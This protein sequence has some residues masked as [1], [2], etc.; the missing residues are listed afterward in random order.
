MYKQAYQG[1]THIVLL[2]A[3]G[4]D[5]MK[6]WSARRGVAARAYNKDVKTYVIDIVGPAGSKVSCPGDAGS[7]G[8]TGGRVLGLTQPYFALQVYILKD[9]PFSLDLAVTDHLRNRIRLLFSTSYKAVKVTPLHARIPL[10]AVAGSWSC[11]VFDLHE[12]V[13]A[14]F[15]KSE[16]ASV[17]TIDLMPV[18]T[19]LRAL[20]CRACPLPTLELFCQ[21]DEDDARRNPHMPRPRFSSRQHAPLPRAV[22]AGTDVH[23]Q[24][25]D[26]FY[27]GL[28]AE[29]R[30]HADIAVRDQDALVQARTEFVP[31]YANTGLAVDARPRITKT[32]IELAPPPSAAAQQDTYAR[33][34]GGTG[35]GAGAGARR[36]SDDARRYAVVASSVR[37]SPGPKGAGAGAGTGA[38]AGAASSQ[39]PK[40]APE[41]QPRVRGTPALKAALDVARGAQQAGGSG[42]GGGG[43]APK[44]TYT[45][46]PSARRALP[47]P[48][49]TLGAPAQGAH[50]EPAVDLSLKAVPVFL[51]PS[52]H[53]ASAS[54]DG[55]S[56][57]RPLTPVYRDSNAVVGL[58]D[59]MDVYASGEDVARST[60]SGYAVAGNALGDA[61]RAYGGDA[62]A[63]EDTHRYS[64]GAGARTGAEAWPSPLPT[65]DERDGSSEFLDG[66]AHTDNVY[67]RQDVDIT[68]DSAIPNEEEG[69]YDFSASE[70]A[71][72]REASRDDNDPY[73]VKSTICMGSEPSGASNVGSIPASLIPALP[74][75]EGISRP[76][77]QPAIDAEQAL[78]PDPRDVLDTLN[79]A[80]DESVIP[81][82]GA[83]L[84]LAP[85]L[86]DGLVYDPTNKC[87]LDPG[88]PVG[89]AVDDS[90]IEDF[91]L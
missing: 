83:N 8:G 35:A 91:S 24:V 41:R 4:Q 37:A 64:F 65:H 18:C 44:P 36:G 7:T 78:I 48:V 28:F 40:V 74:A 62:R 9:Q 90:G 70:H 15:P 39:R 89:L 31:G 63:S 6:N 87:Y 66:S 33:L 1:G 11:L 82:P 19:L 79:P 60:G 52:K 69:D 50:E 77:K 3:K 16:F 45:D 58:V 21:S 26:E 68:V 25:F 76:S 59:D 13:R 29:G 73:T 12:L 42:G 22:D 81:E 14:L 54:A 5:F 51:R 20:T 2:E 85:A 10:H 72:S 88:A 34:S 67:D 49:K 53:G 61:D 57:E 23:V 46:A 27:L 75:S 17:Q 43:D 32:V 38:G 86:A 55:V 84:Q 47:S 56:T 80:E 30:A 71:G